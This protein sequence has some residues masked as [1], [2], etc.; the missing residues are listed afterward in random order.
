MPI[1]FNCACGKSFSVKEEFAG[2]KTK[3]PAC[4]A[5]LIV[6]AV[7]SSPSSEDDA[8]RLLESEETAEQA[9]RPPPRYDW[10][11]PLDASPA[12]A[13]QTPTPTPPARKRPR[14]VPNHEP[15]E[16]RGFR[17]SL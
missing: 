2:K 16:R 12:S 10:R 9:E 4:G 13:P 3:C 6:P 8:F 7:S 11:R 5:A 17:I 1:A 15:E 14:S